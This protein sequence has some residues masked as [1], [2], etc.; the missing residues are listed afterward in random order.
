[1][2]E[3]GTRFLRGQLV[4][5]SA[6]PGT[7]KSA[8]VLSLALRARV[9]TLY[10]SADSDAFTQ[11]SRSV[12]MLTGWPL[13]KS[14]EAVRGGQLGDAAGLFQGIPIRFNYNASPTL[15][16]IERT[17]LAYDEVYGDFPVLIVI[18]NV[19]NVRSGG[20]GDDDPFSGLESLMDYLHDMG[21]QTGGCVIG[22]HHVTG[23]YNDADKAIPLSGVKGQITRVPEMVLTLHR[24]TSDADYGVDTL[25]VSTVKNRG[26][27]SDPSGVDAAE[28]EFIGD[29]MQI[30]DFLYS[31]T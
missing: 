13:E 1:M 18:D 10:F 3:K 28:L 4:L 17:M 29:T 30:R 7:G 21:R 12:A 6:G 11:A 19:T 9:P 8:F 31:T 20:D 15:D 26:G 24:K 25:Y 16:D 23:T 2:E 27:K 5:V 14:A 22:L